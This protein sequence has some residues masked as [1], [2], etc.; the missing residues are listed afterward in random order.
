MDEDFSQAE[1]EEV[2]RS[3]QRIADV[4]VE[5]I[6]LAKKS[7][8][9]ATK[10]SRVRVARD[11]IE[12]LKAEMA[13]FDFMQIPNLGAIEW[14]IVQIEW[15]ARDG[16]WVTIAEGNERGRAAEKA[17]DIDEALAEYEYLADMGAGSP[18]TY[19]RLAAIYKKLKKPEEEVRVLR[20]ALKNVNQSNV[21]DFRWFIDRLANLAARPATNSSEDGD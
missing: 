19:R 5:S 12:L 1:K 18:L 17:G 2:G 14:E 10:M 9:Y 13:R 8:N 16:K 6:E 21:E 11:N 20:A 15:A 7:S 4:I 3:A